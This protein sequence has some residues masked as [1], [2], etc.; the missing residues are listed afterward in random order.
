M[1]FHPR[2]RAAVMTGLGPR[3]AERKAL[4]EANAGGT[5]NVIAAAE[6]TNALTV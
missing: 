1:L 2:S 6:A 5:L 3:T 4:G